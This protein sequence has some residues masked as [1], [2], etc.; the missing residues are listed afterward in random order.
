MHQEHTYSCA[1]HHQIQSE[2]W[3]PNR[4][5]KQV[6]S[7]LFLEYTSRQLSKA[8]RQTLPIDILLSKNRIVCCS[9]DGPDY[10]ECSRF[11]KK[12]TDWPLATTIMLYTMHRHSQCICFI[13]CDIIT[14]HFVLTWWRRNDASQTRHNYVADCLE[15]MIDLDET[16]PL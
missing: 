13:I 6:V 11:T 16:K 1:W 2:L 9:A 5:V 7:Y 10:Y 4:T 8:N 12:Y 15:T 3:F 14:L